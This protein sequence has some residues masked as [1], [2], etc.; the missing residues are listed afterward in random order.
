MN[1]AEM[2][3]MLKGCLN[4]PLGAETDE[5]T[6]PQLNSLLNRGLLAIQM[7]VARINPAAFLQVDTF[8]TVAF[9]NIYPVPNGLIAI[10]K[11]ICTR[12]GK[13]LAKRSDGYMDHTFGPSV[14]SDLSAVEGVSSATDPTDY[15][16]FGRYIRLGP[17]PNNARANAISLTYTPSLT[18][19]DDTDVPQ[20]AE[21][22][23]DAIVNKAW[24][25]GIRN[26]ADI[27]QKAAA[28]QALES[29]L[30]D[31]DDLAGV[32]IDG[33]IQVMP[34]FDPVDGWYGEPSEDRS[35]LR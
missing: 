23:H 9:K 18:M 2:R 26:N 25:L 8:A 14:G 6:I 21:G 35:L 32:P 1:R 33:G 22:L 12:T 5:F 13:R 11:V 15:S 19:A 34:D 20:V 31:F 29:S 3:E 27:G 28:S 7:K 24:T 17:T 30:E 10:R 4:E 16:P